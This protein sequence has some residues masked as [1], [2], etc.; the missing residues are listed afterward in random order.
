MDVVRDICSTGLFLR[1]MENI[2]VRQPLA[3]MLIVLQD[4]KQNTLLQQF[5]HII[6]DEMN[7]KDIEYGCDLDT[8]TSLKLVLNFSELAKRL[9][10][11]MKN[12]ISDNRC[13]LWKL[14]GKS[15][16]I[17]GEDLLPSEFSLVLKSKGVGI[18]KILSDNSGIVILDSTMTEELILEGYARDLVRE[19]QQARKEAK[20]NISDRIMIYIKSDDARILQ[21]VQM[22]GGFIADQTLSVLQENIKEIRYT[23]QCTIEECQVI[24]NMG[25][26]INMI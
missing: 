10:H 26:T 18:S 15:I 17:S 22:F 1:N 13:G 24:I 11:K 8:Y 9:S 6:K 21:V 14:N 23:V 16:T 12:I 20:Y 7:V 5:D 4:V 25:R 3:K 2:R 19:I